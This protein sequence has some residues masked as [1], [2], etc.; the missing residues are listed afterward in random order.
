MLRSAKNGCNYEFELGGKKVYHEWDYGLPMSHLG[1]K[2]NKDEWIVENINDKSKLNDIQ[3]LLIDWELY[4][5][6]WF[7][8]TY[9]N[10]H[11]FNYKSQFGNWGPP[12]ELNYLK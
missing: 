8:N 3:N 4:E 7:V 11:L 12:E 1:K 6:G 10:P 9:K 2:S 5:N